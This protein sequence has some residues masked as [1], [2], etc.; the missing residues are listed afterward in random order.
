MEKTLNQFGSVPN[1]N[2]ISPILFLK[3]FAMTDRNLPEN[4]G[5]TVEF[6]SNPRCR[7]VFLKLI[8]P[9]DSFKM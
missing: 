1:E 2:F 7:K 6:R 3:T 9:P 4:E 8:L 5:S